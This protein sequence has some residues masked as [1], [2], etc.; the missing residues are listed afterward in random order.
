MWKENKPIAGLDLLIFVFVPSCSPHEYPCSQVFLMQHLR[1]DTQKA[2][3]N[4]TWTREWPCSK[5]HC[6]PVLAFIDRQEL[7][8]STSPTLLGSLHSFPKISREH[9]QEAR[10][11][12]RAKNMIM[13][14]TLPFAILFTS[15]CIPTP[16]SKGW[17]NR[18]ENDNHG[19][20]S[21]KF[22]FWQH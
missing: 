15:S 22:L 12:L 11:A 14:Q 6:S 1:P 17:Q 2:S 19:P 5:R 3:R 8:F 4:H 9:T 16:V 10:S 18:G 21:V 20:T 13:F 7:A